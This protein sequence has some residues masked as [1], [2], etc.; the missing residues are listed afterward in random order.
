M[1]QP[2][3]SPHRTG[4]TS[5]HPNRFLKGGGGSTRAR[6]VRKSVPAHWPATCHWG[7]IWV[8]RG[9]HPSLTHNFKRHRPS[10]CVPDTAMVRGCGWFR[11]SSSAG[12]GGGVP[13]RLREYAGWYFR[14]YVRVHLSRGE[15]SAWGWRG[16]GGGVA[17]P[18]GLGGVKKGAGECRAPRGGRRRVG[19]YANV[20]FRGPVAVGLAGVLELPL[21]R[22]PALHQLLQFEGNR[23]VHGVHGLVLWLLKSAPRASSHRTCPTS[24]HQNRFLK[25]GVGEGGTRARA[26]KK[27]VRASWLTNA[28]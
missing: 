27:S 11:G 22:E 28:I 14:V 24:Y 1:P 8:Y 13:S 16:G 2:R 10:H 6:A 21:L 3:A 7:T 23:A 18:L 19:P 26:L 25:G 20:G 12:G 17:R 9:E 5:N 4:P 15:P